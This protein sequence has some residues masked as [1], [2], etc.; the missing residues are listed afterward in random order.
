MTDKKT[1]IETACDA[2][3]KKIFD[4]IPGVEPEFV[5]AIEPLLRIVFSYG[6]SFAMDEIMSLQ[7]RH[8][9]NGKT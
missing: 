8:G 5:E 6:A 2:A 7:K 9:E 3:C 1:A 4:Q